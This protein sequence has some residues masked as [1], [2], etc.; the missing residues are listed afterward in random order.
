MPVRKGNGQEWTAMHTHYIGNHLEL[1][2]RGVQ[3]WVELLQSFGSHSEENSRHSLDDPPKDVNYSLIQLVEQHPIWLFGAGPLRLWTCRFGEWLDMRSN[4]ACDSERKKTCCLGGGNAATLKKG[5][6]YRIIKSL[7]LARW[8]NFGMVW[9]RLGSTPRVEVDSKEVFPHFGG[10]SRLCEAERWDHTNSLKS[11][12]LCV[13]VFHM[14]FM[15]CHQAKLVSND[16]WES[17]FRPAQLLLQQFAH[18]Y[19]IHLWICIG[20]SED[21]VPSNHE[22][23]KAL[24]S[25]WPRIVLQALFFY[26]QSNHASKSSKHSNLKQTITTSLNL[27]TYF[28]QMANEWQCYWSHGI[29]V[30]HFHLFWGHLLWRLA[31]LARG[32]KVI[33][34]WFPGE[35][36]FIRR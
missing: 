23:S 10:R 20:S 8:M 25:S 1:V 21:S 22:W 4:P 29:A 11:F 9:L 36:Y 2:R 26:T 32:P 31:E 16:V 13:D 28:Y 27:V 33:E 34:T 19:A 24:P 5:A 7:N 18:M 17:V 6:F 14:R 35:V 3:G 30:M 15:T 12:A